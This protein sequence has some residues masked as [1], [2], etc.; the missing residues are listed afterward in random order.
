[1]ADNVNRI[2]LN[3]VT[4]D[5]AASR[6]SDAGGREVELRS[7]S[8]A[9]L[10]R[11]AENPGTV[12]SKEALTEAVWPGVAVT[13]DSL[14]QCISEIRRALGDETKTILRTVPKRGYRLDPPPDP[15]APRGAA[16]LSR[17][18]ML[19]GIAFTA[20]ALVMASAALRQPAAETASTPKVAVLPFDDMSAAQDLAYLGDGL[21]DDVISMLARSP[22]VVV[23]ARGSSFAYGDDPVDVRVI[24]DELGVDYVLEGSVRREGDMLRVVAQLVDAET[25]TQ[26]WAERFEEA[27]GDPPALMDAV[28]GRV[29]TSLASER[30]ALKAAQF[31]EAWGQDS[32]SL[33]EYDH[34]LRGLAIHVEAEDYET[35]ARAAAIWQEGLSA[36]PDS[37][38]LKGKLAWFHWNVAWEWLSDDITRDFEEADRLVTE[39]LAA[40]SLDPEVRRSALWLDAYVRMRRGQY[41]EAVEAAERAVEM[42]PYDA[43]VLRN[44]TEVLAAAGRYDMALD[45]LAT[46]E[47]REPGREATY[48][49]FRGY[50]YRLM[51]RYEESI[52]QYLAAG[53]MVP[54]QYLSM[55]V[56]YVRLGRVDEAKSI[57]A[58]VLTESPGWTQAGWREGSFYSDPAVLDAE[59]EALASA[60]LP[61]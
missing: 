20:L 40:D 2:M 27:G 61:A 30:G 4:V 8:F 7:Q 43:R 1:M 51:G 12:V 3:G 21:A 38:L 22:D 16:L 46:A 35:F 45:W 17:P 54:Y 36:Y 48:H 59:I 55:A 42:A 26:V 32:A 15:G 13:E 41:D 49:R 18:P 53:E 23:M 52:E 37:T 6:L 33:G 5:F 19:A 11:L 31:R 25:G 9:V 24:G 14:V 28:A 60:G 58:D 50:L 57:V 10:R 44:L 47:V 39:V 34:F 29:V 56:S